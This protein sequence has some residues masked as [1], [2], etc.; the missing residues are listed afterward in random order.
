MQIKQL[1]TEI[2]E[3][4]A[5]VITEEDSMMKLKRDLQKQRIDNE[6]IE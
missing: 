4:T 3:L 2:Q 1:K 5:S 6:D